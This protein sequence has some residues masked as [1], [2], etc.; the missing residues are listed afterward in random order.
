MFAISALIQE[1]EALED[2]VDL[3]MS[4][5][6]YSDA[7]LEDGDI[8]TSDDMVKL[9][10]KSDD[11]DEEYDSESDDDKVDSD[12]DEDSDEDEEDE[13]SDDDDDLDEDK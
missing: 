10:E 9:L 4:S 5:D 11:E 3:S 13:D 1:M 8:L 12:D 7:M 2:E 6:E